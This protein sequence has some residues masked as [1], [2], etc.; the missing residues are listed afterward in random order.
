VKSQKR[1]EVRSIEDSV[2]AHWEWISPE[3]AQVLLGWNWKNRALDPH[4][5]SKLVADMEGGRFGVN[6]SATIT[7]GWLDGRRWLLDGQHRLEAIVQ[8][9]V[10]QYCLVCDFKGT[11]EEAIALMSRIGIGAKS[12]G[13]D[14]VIQIFHGIQNASNH[15]SAARVI[16]SY[17]KGFRGAQAGTLPITG[18]EVQEFVIGHIDQLAS[19]LVVARPVKIFTPS[20]LEA[21]AFILL[22]I[23]EER[24]I[25]F[26]HILATGEA[27]HRLALVVRERIIRER[28]RPGGVK[29]DG[30]FQLGLLFVTWNRWLRGDRVTNIEF[31]TYENARGRRVFGWPPPE[32]D[33]ETGR[34]IEKFPKPHHP[35]VKF[36]R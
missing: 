20:I 6:T 3:R 10:E 24:A 23:D 1:T 19:A 18:A 17:R 30:P 2:S 11:E 31:P 4:H 16:L 35:A 7:I 34:V 8:S 12:R 22:G 5:K 29:F 9:G 27:D 15:T 26:F 33:S 21:A 14:G 32:K 13:N 25:D 28:L 36:A